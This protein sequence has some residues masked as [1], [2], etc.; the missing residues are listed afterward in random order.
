MNQVDFVTNGN[1]EITVILKLRLMST[2][3]HYND[4]CMIILNFY[5]RY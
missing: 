4:H 3:E 2:Y 5:H 1:Y